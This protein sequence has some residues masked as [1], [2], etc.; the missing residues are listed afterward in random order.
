MSRFGGARGDYLV[1]FRVEGIRPDGMSWRMADVT[2]YDPEHFD[3]G[4]GREVSTAPGDPFGVCHA[5]VRVSADTSTE[6][7]RSARQRLIAGL[8]CYSFGL[9]GNSLRPD[10]NPSVMDWEYVV[11]LSEEWGGFNYEREVP[12]HGEQGAADLDL[13]GIAR[14]YAALLAKAV[15][16]P[17]ELTQLQDRFVR[18]VHWLREARFDADPAK[19]FVL[20]YVGMEHIF[21]RGEGSDAVA[22]LAPRLNKTWRDIGRPLVQLNMTF[23]RLHKTLREDARL[24]EIAESDGRLR[25]WDEDERVLLDPDKVRV[26]LDRMPK[27][28]EEAR[29]SASML[30]GILESLRADAEPIAAHVERLRDLQTVKV[31][32]LQMLRNTI[33]HDALYQ[34]ERMR[35]YAQEAH[36]ILDDALDKMVGE[37]ISEDPD[38]K[39]ID[40]LVEKYDGQPW[41]SS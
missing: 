8:D 6:A 9:S 22:R 36:E 1:V 30:L 34:D 32:L 7:V 41:A 15:G 12:F 23:N 27:D 16:N 28:H 13:P 40:Q 24:R 18:A 35:Y 17:R 33:V 14:A 38:C 25:N 11:N 29:G 4:E 10:F 19:R 39:T 2:F 26:L 21:A 20:H 5:A 37:V 31:R 3:Y